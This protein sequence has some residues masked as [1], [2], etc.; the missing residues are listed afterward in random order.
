VLLVLNRSRLARAVDGLSDVSRSLEDLHE[1]SADDE[2]TLDSIIDFARHVLRCEHAGV[3]LVYPGG[4]VESAAASDPLVVLADELQMTLR[5]G[6]GLAD[7]A[8]WQAEVIP[9]TVTVTESRWPRWTQ[10]ARLI[11]IRNL[12]SVRLDC[13]D[14]DPVASLTMYNQVDMGFTLRD[15]PVAQ[16][17]AR[18]A[19]VVLA[20]ASSALAVRGEVSS[21]SVIRQA[22]G[23]LM[24]R[25]A[26]NAAQAF[27][28]L[29]QRSVDEK[30]LLRE[31]A[32]RIV[33]V[34]DL[35]DPTRA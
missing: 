18:H 25:Y 7:M 28:L 10:A 26:L 33:D 13:A 5:E 27:A 9:Q 20:G 14:G 21:R 6:P 15:V 22:E 12:L 3:L 23:I 32:Q 35:P 11:G 16:L 1:P 2:Q 4:G 24:Q 19:S 17:L 34:R 29:R 8:A 31:T 30:L